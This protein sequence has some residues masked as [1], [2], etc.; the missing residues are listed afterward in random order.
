MILVLIH[1]LQAPGPAGP[2]APAEGFVNS[3]FHTDQRFMDKLVPFHNPFE[4][5]FFHKKERIYDVY[6]SQDEMHRPL[7]IHTV[8]PHLIH[9]TRV[10]LDELNDYKLDFVIDTELDVAPK[11][12]GKNVHGNIRF[13]CSL[14]SPALLLIAPNDSNIVDMGDIK[15]YSCKVVI[16]VDGDEITERHQALMQLLSSYSNDTL[17]NIEV[18]HLS[19]EKLL[20]GYGSDY[21]VYADLAVLKNPVI[22]ALTDKVPSHLV[23]IRKINSGS[24]QV[25]YTERPFYQRYPF[26]NKH[27]VD[28]QQLQR[29]YPML[30]PVHNRD[31][32]Y[33][34]I[35]THYVLLCHN[36]IP[37]WK[38]QDVM[39]KTLYLM[40]VH[41]PIDSKLD[42]L[43]QREK[44]EVSKLFKGTTVAELAHIITAIPAHQGAKDVF[45][46]LHLHSTSTDGDAG[47][48]YYSESH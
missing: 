41:W 2:Q 30:A 5:E 46:E 16:A 21:T 17:D 47:G 43:E 33:P 14:Y 42:S 10:P 6:A 24:H 19:R 20:N 38:I 45:A 26:Y 9:H 48:D 25:T 34:T 13:V 39:H 12:M 11:Y 23:S 44:Q 15:H 22:K 7:L 1:A 32:Y 29:Y 4:A 31:L 37:A 8:G 27:M 28:I 35:H 36:K 18:L 40:K 3:E